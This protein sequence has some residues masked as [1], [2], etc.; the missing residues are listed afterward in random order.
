MTKHTHKK[1][2]AEPGPE[3]KTRRYLICKTPFLSGWAGERIC[4]RCKGT[5]KWRSGIA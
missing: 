4:R 3:S 5:E 2:D 1:P